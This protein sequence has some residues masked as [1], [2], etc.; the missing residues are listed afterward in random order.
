MGD[1]E[2]EM[3]GELD[4]QVEALPE[5]WKYLCPAQEEGRPATGPLVGKVVKFLND[6]EEEEL[7]EEMGRMNPATGPLVGKVVKFLNDKE[8]EE[9]LEEMGR[10]NPATGQSLLMWAVLQQKFLLVEWLLK[11]A[12][13]TAFVFSDVEKEVTIYDKF[14]EKR[15]EREQEEKDRLEAIKAGDIDPEEEDPDKEPPAAIHTLVKADL[16][17]EE[18]ID[19][20]KIHR[21]GELGLYQG[22]RNASNRTKTGLGKSLFVNGDAYIGE[23]RDNKRHG[24]GCYWWEAT[25]EIY[26]GEWRNNQRNGNGRMVYQDGGRY[27]GTWRHNER[28]GNGRYTYPTGDT[29]SGTWNNGVKHG[30]GTYT[31][32]ADS[33]QLIGTFE[34]GNFNTGE[35]RLA[36]GSRY[37]GVFKDFKPVG[38][39]IFFHKHGQ[40]GAYAQDGEYIDGVWVSSNVRSVCDQSPTLDITAQGNVLKLTC[41]AHLNIKILVLVQVANFPPFEQWL[42][43]VGDPNVLGR[44]FTL[45]K[46]EVRAVDWER[47]GKALKSVSIGVAAVDAKGERWAQVGFPDPDTLVFT[48]KSTFLVPVLTHMG[49]ERMIHLKQPLMSVADTQAATLLEVQQLPSGEV[50]SRHVDTLRKLGLCI[51]AQSL[52]DVSKLCAANGGQGTVTHPI[53]CDARH[54]VLYF[55]QEVTKDYWNTLEE[56][57]AEANGKRSLQSLHACHPKHFIQNCACAASIAG[58]HLVQSLKPTKVLPS[59]TWAPMRPPTPPPPVAE[60]R[61]QV[62]LV[63]S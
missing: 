1:N 61:P 47:G 50:R 62:C 29:Y 58:A 43:S 9:L 57:I 34:E 44:G 26:V 60:P 12:K 11:R 21:I 25:G 5:L 3:E 40:E 55:C 20:F 42:A 48:K 32:A 19:E 49:E 17:D 24:I 27:Y 18:G 16:G 14:V 56:R 41:A 4:E 30:S 38:R 37:Y 31:V 13:R 8:E 6:K 39:G 2:E 45:T 35:W 15:K 22:M 51:E 10:M 33:S 59:K 36:G 23:Y 7:L 53:E 52:V 54:R 46:L 63:M 28:V